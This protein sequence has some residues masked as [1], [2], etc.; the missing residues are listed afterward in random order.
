MAKPDINTALRYAASC[1]YGAE[2]FRDTA[3]IDTLATTPVWTIGHGTTRVDGEPVCQG[4]SC[5]RQQ[6]DTWAM[7]AMRTTGAEVLAAV[8]VDLNEMQLAALISLAYNIGIGA[9]RESTVLKALNEERFR[10]AADDFLEYNEAGHRVRPG[11]VTR[12]QRERAMFLTGM[13][14]SY[15]G[16]IRETFAAAVSDA[17]LLRTVV[18]N[19]TEKPTVVA[20]AAEAGTGPT[21]ETLPAAAADTSAD[22]LNAAELGKLKGA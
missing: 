8:R 2:G 12:R 15:D 17:A 5:T 10:L 7:D 11:L 4:M 9:F 16:P 3:F 14:V 13:G 19:A 18:A 21:R 22:Q 20:N 1:V 6:A